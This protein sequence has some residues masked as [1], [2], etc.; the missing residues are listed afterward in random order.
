[1]SDT[2][3]IQIVGSVGGSGTKVT[4]GGE[5]VDT[6]D[7]DTKVNKTDYATANVAGLVKGAVYHG[8]KFN[9]GG[10]MEIIGAG[11][12]EIDAKKQLYKPITP[13]TLDYA[14]KSGVTTNTLTLTTEEQ[15]NAQNWLGVGD[16]DK[17]IENLEG[18]LLTFVE[19]SSTAYEKDVPADAAP[20]AI[21]NSISGATATSKNLFDPS[22]PDTEG[23]TYTVNADGSI[24]IKGTYSSR[25]E[26]IYWNITLD[27]GTYYISSKREAI[28]VDAVCFNYEGY[29]GSIV[30]S[31]RIEIPIVLEFD[32]YGYSDTGEVD[33][34]IYILLTK[35]ERVSASTD[36][37]PYFSYD[38][39]SVTEV[40]SVDV[41]GEVVD[42]CTIPSGIQS[43]AGYGE[44]YTFL[45]FDSKIYMDVNGDSV[46]VSTYLTDYADFKFI[47]VQPGGKLI[48]VNEY[49][50][51]VPSTVTYVK[52]KE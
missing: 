16:H 20:Y 35:D 40:K 14:I 9:A 19:D 18:T 1:M 4:V 3:K 43:Q 33:G 25:P 7:A 32:P 12:D 48:F 52:R 15:Q 39:V 2:P 30:L 38:S 46:D 10:D 13:L 5:V 44:V 36:W 45:D 6:F 23:N 26:Q 51:P 49:G 47:K 27:P 11:H 42:T 29:M 50:A 31:E 17:R 21:L 28:M 37:E 34:K 24:Q 22:T 41:S 8:I